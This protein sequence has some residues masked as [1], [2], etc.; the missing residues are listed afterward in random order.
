MGWA[1]RLRFFFG[2]RLLIPLYMTLA[3]GPVLF[4]M[5]KDLRL[6]WLFLSAHEIMKSPLAW[7][8]TGDFWKTMSSS[9]PLREVSPVGTNLGDTAKT[10]WRLLFVGMISH[11]VLGRTHFP[12]SQ[13]EMSRV[14]GIGV[15]GKMDGPATRPSGPSI[16]SVN[17]KGHRC[18]WEAT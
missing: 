7:N 16:F 14:L 6:V 5:R 8:L 15:P 17:Q 4:D 10:P 11:I 18:F 13:Q 9:N 3:L 12:R 1:D 2:A